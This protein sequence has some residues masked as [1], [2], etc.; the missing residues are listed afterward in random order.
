M[1]IVTLFSIL[2]ILNFFKANSVGCSYKE[3][4]ENEDVCCHI[5]VFKNPLR[6]KC[7]IFQFNTP[8]NDKNKK[9]CEYYVEKRKEDKLSKL[10]SLQ[11]IMKNTLNEQDMDDIKDLF[12]VFNEKL[13]KLNNNNYKFGG[14]NKGNRNVNDIDDLLIEFNN[15]YFNLKDIQVN[16]LNGSNSNKEM[17]KNENDENYNNFVKGESNYIK[18]KNEILQNSPFRN[19][20]CLKTLN[21]YNCK[22]S[23]DKENHDADEEIDYELVESIGETHYY[24]N[25][26]HLDDTHQ[27]GNSTSEIDEEEKHIHDRNENDYYSSDYYNSMYGTNYPSEHGKSPSSSLFYLS[28]KFYLVNML[29]KNPKKILQKYIEFKEYLSSSEE[30]LEDFLDNEYYSTTQTINS[31]LSDDIQKTVE[32]DEKGDQHSNKNN[33]G[34]FSSLFYD[35]VSL[36]YFPKKNVEL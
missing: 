24:S 30:K 3:S 32:Y 27:K 28:K 29:S 14:P 23:N 20:K 19:E 18:K 7:Y 16:I 12:P 5:N 10:Y 36:F 2:L 6:Y 17:K 34:F 22:K 1:T 26:E 13:L 15:K 9:C 35:L 31:I 33:R 21:G 25:I 8:R 4:N 11:D